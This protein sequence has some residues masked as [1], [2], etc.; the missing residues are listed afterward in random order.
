MTIGDKEYD[1]AIEA[2]ATAMWQALGTNQ[3]EVEHYGAIHDQAKV[4]VEAA[5]WKLC[6]YTACQVAE[7]I[8]ESTAGITWTSG[9][10]IV[11]QRIAQFFGVSDEDL[12][13]AHSEYTARTT[14]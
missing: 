4:A 2:A 11:L 12:Q 3:P 9:V 7:A 13:Q 5:R 1:G 8:A 14:A 10:E 6:D